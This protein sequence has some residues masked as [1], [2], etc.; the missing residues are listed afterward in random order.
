MLLFSDQT[1]FIFKGGDFLTPKNSSISQT[2]EYEA[3][4]AAKPAAAGNTV[5]FPASRGGFTAVREYYVID[6]TDRSTAND[7]TSHVS[8]YV[9]D[10]VYA[11]N[12][13]TTENA[14][15]AL[16]TTDTSTIYV[17]KYHYAGREKM[18]SAWFKYTFNDL[19]VLNAAFIESSLFVVG[20]KSGK[21]IL[22]KIQ[23]D[24][25]RFDTNQTYVTRLD[26][27][28]TEAEC[29]TSYNSILDKTV[30][31][32]P[33]ALDTP[34]L[35]T[36]GTSSG[37]VIP[38]TGGGSSSLIVSGDKTSTEFYCGEKYTMTYQFSEPTLKEPTAGGGRVA[39]AGGRLQIKHWILRFQDS[40]FF[41]VQVSNRITGVVTEHTYTGRLV[42]GGENIM[43]QPQHHQV[44]LVSNND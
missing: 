28:F 43:A 12:A 20:N 7:V 2:T 11:M 26:F 9:P 3:S 4:T 16:T 44:T 22:F 38:I 35:V 29:S 24:E 19:E 6:D 15:V 13:S 25:G 1:Q 31:T 23:F 8:K 32:L 34:F 41:T 40:G 37:E 33:F 17:Y 18:Q 39:I 10:G 21:T 42:G 27:R 5:Y 30:I 14:L 36:R